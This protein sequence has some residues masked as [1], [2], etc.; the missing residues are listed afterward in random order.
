ML[1]GV[2]VVLK[3]FKTRTHMVRVASLLHQHMRHKV[4]LQQK[5]PFSVATVGASWRLDWQ[6]ETGRKNI[7][8]NYA[9]SF[10][11]WTLCRAV[12]IDE[13]NYSLA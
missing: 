7:W 11:P 9:V 1:T 13:C 2:E 5:P 6:Q 8:T 4:C 10:P 12:R 3:Q